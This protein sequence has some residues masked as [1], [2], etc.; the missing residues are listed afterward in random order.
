MIHWKESLFML[1]QTLL[2][3]GSFIYS[4]SITIQLYNDGLPYLF[5]EWTLLSTKETLLWISQWRIFWR[6]FPLK[7]QNQKELLRKQW[8][9]EAQ[10]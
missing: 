2:H 4:K 9:F 8:K 10:M 1:M 6:E 7:I 5:K 3:F